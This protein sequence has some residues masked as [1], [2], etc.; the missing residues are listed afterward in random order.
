VS[1]V[2]HRFCDQ[3]RAVIRQHVKYAL[4]QHGYCFVVMI[5]K[6]PY[7]RDQIGGAGQRVVQ[8]VSA[9]QLNLLCI[10]LR[11]IADSHNR[12]KIKQ[13]KLQLRVALPQR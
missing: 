9:L 10:Q 3:Q 13:G 1:R 8:K 6:N 2:R 4:Q 12:S 7:Q 5:V 11:L